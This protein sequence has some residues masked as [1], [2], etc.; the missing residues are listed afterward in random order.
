MKNNLESI[1]ENLAWK[2]IMKLNRKIIPRWMSL[3]KSRT[4]RKNFAGDMR[5]S[6]DRWMSLKKCTGRYKGFAG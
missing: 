1:K 5:Q 6:F 4:L 3:T 2:S